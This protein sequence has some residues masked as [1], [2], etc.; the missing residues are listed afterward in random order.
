MSCKKGYVECTNIKVH[1]CSSSMARLSEILTLGMGRRE[2]DGAM[3][4]V[5]VSQ[6]ALSKS[7]QVSLQVLRRVQKFLDSGP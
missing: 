5:V 2:R 4:M 1:V 7:D 3:L 6:D